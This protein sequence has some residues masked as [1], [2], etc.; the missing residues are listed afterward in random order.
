MI[1]LPPGWARTTLGDLVTRIEAGRSFGAAA[2]PAHDDEWGIIRVSAMT[3]GEFRAE[4]NKAVLNSANVNPDYEIRP[5]DVLV[6][7]ANTADYVGAPV[8]VGAT[9]QRLL[10]SDKSLRLVVSDFVD[11]RWLVHILSSPDVR[12]QISAQATGTKDS[13]RNIP[14][15]KLREV[16]IPLPPVCEQRRIV[17]VLEA[18]LSRIE[19]GERS[20]AGVEDK[21]T[22]IRRAVIGEA[23]AELVGC[24]TTLGEVLLE[25]LTS[26]RSV[27]TRAG[28]FGVLRLTA[29]KE[30]RIDVAERKDGAWSAEEAAPFLIRKDDFLVSRGNGS[31]DLVGRGGLVPPNPPPVAFPDTLIRVRT[32]QG[33]VHKD[34]LRILWDSTVIR[35]QI[36]A[37]ARTTAGIHKI[38]QVLLRGLELPVPSLSRQGTIVDRVEAVSSTAAR[39][40]EIMRTAQLRGAQLRRSLLTEAFAGR[41]VPQDPA[42]APASVLLDR[43]RAERDTAGPLRRRREAGSS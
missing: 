29:L 20:L 39:C 26:G 38:N 27:P 8:L 31:L 1:D 33:R 10:L 32:D 12:R 41:L 40:G 15:S 4:E 6:S 19:V 13:M 43:I 3:W 35:S 37:G 2:R 24:E 5:G 34:Y 7:R 36:E 22:I 14:Q 21:T 9:R 16:E 28:G 42:D 23:L 18:H 30:G 25:P 17:G 11:R